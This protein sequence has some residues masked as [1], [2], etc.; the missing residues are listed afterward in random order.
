MLFSFHPRPP[1]PPQKKR[2]DFEEKGIRNRWLKQ[3]HKINMSKAHSK[4][5]R[6]LSELAVRVKKERLQAAAAGAGSTV[7]L[8]ADQI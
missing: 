8:G 7:D 2:G 5:D 3:A 6:L 4:Q 1:P